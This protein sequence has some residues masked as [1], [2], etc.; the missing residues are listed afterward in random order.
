MSKSI[1]LNRLDSIKK[2]GN[3]KTVL[4]IYQLSCI[5]SYCLF[6]GL[7]NELKNGIR[8]SNQSQLVSG[9]LCLPFIVGF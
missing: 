8:V 1:C 5:L 4:Y 7:I 3:N 6:F 2:E 9:A